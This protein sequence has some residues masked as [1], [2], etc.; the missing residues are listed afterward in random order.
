MPVALFLLSLV[1]VAF[2]VS[3]LVTD[4]MSWP[5]HTLGIAICLF[6][7]ARNAK[8]IRTNRQVASAPSMREVQ[9]A[10]TLDEALGSDRAILYKHS[11]TCPVSAAVAGEVLQFAETHP[12][13]K[14]YVLKVVEHRD[15]S[16]SVAEQLDVPH[17]SPQVFVLKQGR[18]LWHTSH[19]EITVDNLGRQLA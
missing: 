9:D 5:T 3:R 7:V 8:L 13:W 17:E 10:A 16:D 1:G 12:D 19:G 18:L 4:P 15:L 2:F 14:V 6:I 11:T